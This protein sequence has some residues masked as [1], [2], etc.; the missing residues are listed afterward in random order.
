MIY[1]FELSHLTLHYFRTTFIT[2]KIS[3][4]SFEHLR[5]ELFVFKHPVS[6]NFSKSLTFEALRLFKP[7]LS[8]IRVFVH[9]CSELYVLSSYVEL[10]AFKHPVSAN[11]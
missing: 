11:L 3:T 5:L 9:V 8:H 7:V 6:T 10:F 1:I 4:L 2:L